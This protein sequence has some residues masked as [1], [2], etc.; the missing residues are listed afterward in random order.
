MVKRLAGT[1][2]AALEA[3]LLVYE[4]AVRIICAAG[5]QVDLQ[6]IRAGDE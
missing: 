1:C 5:V 3:E 6:E 4:H 2:I